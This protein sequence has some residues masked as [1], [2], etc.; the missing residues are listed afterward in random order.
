MRGDRRRQNCS[1]VKVNIILK[2]FI[3][4]ILQMNVNLF[5]ILYCHY[6]LLSV[7]PYSRNQIVRCLADGR[8]EKAARHK[9]II[10]EKSF[11]IYF[12]SPIPFATCRR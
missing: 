6:R 8:E 1:S 7:H 10:L 12:W 11:E 2:Y 3:I 9:A 5:V 4:K